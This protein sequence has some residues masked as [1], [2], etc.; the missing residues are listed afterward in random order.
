M[1]ATGAQ[2]RL[3]PGPVKRPAPTPTARVG[4]A[5]LVGATAAVAILQVLQQAIGQ[6]NPRP[7]ISVLITAAVGL[8]TLALD[9]ARTRRQRRLAAEEREKKLERTLVSWPPPLVRDADPYEVGVFPRRRVPRADDLYIPR[10]VDDRLAAAIAESPF[11]LVYGPPRSGK[12]RTALETSARA[13]PDA[14]LVAPCGSEGLRDLVDLDPPMRPR[15][16]QAILWLDSLERY[17][18]GIE[19]AMFETLED[20]DVPVTIVATA[21]TTDYEKLLASSGERGDAARAVAARARAFEVPA[22]L[23]SDELKSAE[24]LY[25][26]ED[27][28]SGGPGGRL[29]STGK[30]EHQP[31]EV[32]PLPP[33]V[34]DPPDPPIVRDPLFSIPAGAAIAALALVAFVA[35]V[36]GFTKPVPPTLGEQ[37]DAIKREATAGGRILAQEQKV[38]FHGEPSYLFAFQNKDFQRRAFEQPGPPSDE[39]EIY[40]PVHGKLVRRFRFQPSE[41]G[42]QYQ[43]R[44]AGDLNGNG[45]GELIGGYGFPREASLALVPFIV[46][47][48]D[49]TGKYRLVS[50]EPNAPALSAH[51]RARAAAQPFLDTYNRPVAL[52][53]PKDA[54]NLVGFRV[55]DFAV[56]TKP[57]RLVS[58]LAVDPRTSTKVGRVELQANIPTLSGDQPA[59]TRCIPSHSG[60]LMSSWSPGRLLDLEIA[61]VW[62]PF[63]KTRVCVPQTS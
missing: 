43:F 5:I 10:S 1:S 25:P 35:L 15:A 20:L 46:F 40:D 24:Q 47:W 31:Q 39:L 30:E 16:T 44:F 56:V 28:T 32:E 7:V 14:V 8:T 51:V 54:V 18:D 34:V 57:A 48:D 23:D 61:E 37:A 58:A 2:V 6:F 22:E 3:A 21:R 63:I 17:H 55:Q 33:R 19:P 60:P 29:A 50:L 13:L 36:I 42:A 38:N 4:A 12:S 11:V 62:T 45:E 27:F 49:Q 53:D 59:L 9:R 41:G 26:G 52:T